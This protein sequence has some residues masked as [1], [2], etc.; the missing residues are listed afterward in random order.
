MHNTTQYVVN[1]KQN[2]DIMKLSHKT[3]TINYDTNYTVV[4]TYHILGVSIWSETLSSFDSIE[5]ALE[6]LLEIK[7]GKGIRKR[8]KRLNKC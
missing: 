5:E 3:F 8:I 6:R 4:K 1:S 7:T 2:I